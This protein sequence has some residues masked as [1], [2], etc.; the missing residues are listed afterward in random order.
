LLMRFDI[1]QYS[2][3]DTQWVDTWEK[4]AFDPR[5]NV[6]V[7]PG[8]RKFASLTFPGKDFHESYE[9]KIE[10]VK[11]IWPG[12]KDDDGVFFPKG[13]PYEWQ[14]KTKIIKG[15]VIRI[16]NH[17]QIDQ[18][19]AL[20]GSQAPIVTD[21][22]FILR[23]LGTVQDTGTA[24]EIYGGL[25]YE[26]TGIRS[27]S[28]K[29]T[30]EDAL[31]ESIGIGNIDAGITAKAIFDKLR[32]DQRAA[33]FRSAVTG[34]PRRIDFFRGL[35]GRLD[36]TSGLVVVT[37]DLKQQD[38]DIDVHPVANLLD[39]KDAA[40]EIIFEKPNGLHGY[41]L[42][43]GKGKL[44][45]A[46]PDDVVRD[47]TI[48]AP[49]SSRLQGATSCIACHEAEG[50]DGWKRFT[51]DVKTLTKR[52]LNIFGDQANPDQSDTVDRLKGLYDGD[53]ERALQKGRDDYAAAVLR[54]TGPW[55][56][57]VN[58]VDVVKQAATRITKLWRDYKYDL[59]TPAVA[60]REM[61]MDANPE[62][63]AMTFARVI[64]A[65]SPEDVRIASLR[66][67]VPIP[68][69]DWD[70]VYSFALSRKR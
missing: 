60:L 44:Q 14:R 4:L 17:P 30:D 35:A 21:R 34:N 67:G 2:P 59:V 13:T 7:T 49:H 19:I 24:K 36:T 52:G 58:N 20:T 61:G 10:T 1:R 40:R 9:W 15:G 38:V 43:D 53:P 32:S 16:P 37:H 41:A 46:A 55:K 47:F 45:D 29:G 69:A 51:N 6:L 62:T 33:M 31:F 8:T 68:R 70:L 5:F 57:S 27:K 39:F 63:A 18:L 42:T 23:A 65:S 54:A 64:P 12:G 11:D 48:P 22:Y 3:R 56:G 66:L 25:Y 26:F 28:S 50:S